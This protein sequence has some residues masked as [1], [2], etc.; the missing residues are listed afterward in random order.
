MSQLSVKSTGVKVAVLYSGG[1]DSAITVKFLAREGFDVT[2]IHIYTPF[3]RISKQRIARMG[4]VLGFEVKFLESG[5]DYIV[6]LKKPKYMDLLEESLDDH[7]DKLGLSVGLNNAYP[8]FDCKIYM[9]AEAWKYCRKQ[10]MNFIAMGD[11][12]GQWPE[13]TLTTLKLIDQE[14]GA[15]GHVVRPLCAKLLEPTIPET[16]KIVNREHLFSISGTDKHYHEVLTRELGI[17][18]AELQPVSGGCLLGSA[19]FCA[20]LNK[21]L[22]KKQSISRSIIENISS[23]LVAANKLE[24][25]DDVWYFKE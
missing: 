25:R 16:K 18:I 5:D 10:G 23:K 20:E 9:L 2:P 1:V 3:A 14:A 13:Q 11:V 21:I 22:E 7:K 8:C 12:A 17:N 24:Y 15:F 6:K 4:R 19:D